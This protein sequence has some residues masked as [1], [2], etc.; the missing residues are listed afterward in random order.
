MFHDALAL[1]GE[2][3]PRHQ[4]AGSPLHLQTAWQVMHSLS[5]CHPALGKLTKNKSELHHPRAPAL[6][7][8][9]QA[10]QSFPSCLLS[11]NQ[12]HSLMHRIMAVGY[13]AGLGLSGHWGRQY[14]W[15]PI[16]LG[17]A[18]CHRE[19]ISISPPG[20]TFGKSVS[21]EWSFREGVALYQCIFNFVL[22]AEYLNF[23]MK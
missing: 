11:W 18:C 9:S 22:N 10:W 23:G 21:Q 13:P 8:G 4:R 17:G 14:C 5:G 20:P 1:S 3:Q 6:T 16:D 19:V 15:F 12:L 2:S 7:G